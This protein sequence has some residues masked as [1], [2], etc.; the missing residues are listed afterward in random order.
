M[1][2]YILYIPLSYYD[3]YIFVVLDLY[4]PS[5]LSLVSEGEDT[6]KVLCFILCIAF[7]IFMIVKNQTIQIALL[8]DISP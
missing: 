1:L 3:L 2:C 6:E 4:S 8:L 5:N 7:P